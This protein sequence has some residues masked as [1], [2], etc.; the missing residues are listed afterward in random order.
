MPVGD[1]EVPEDLKRRYL[2]TGSKPELFRRVVDTI[3]FEE[4]QQ[5][6]SL[7]IEEKFIPAGNTLVAGVHPILPNCSIIGEVSDSNFEEVARRA[8]QLWQHAIGIGFDLTLCTD[9]VATLRRLSELSK[10]TCLAW[11]RPIRGNMATLNASHPKVSAFIACKTHS[12]TAANLLFNFNISVAVEDSFMSRA[13]ADRLSPEFE[14][15]RAIAQ[16]AW[17]YGDPGVVFLDRVQSGCPGESRIVT[18]V[19]CGEQFMHTNETCTLGAMNLDA[20][21]KENQFDYSDFRTSVKLAIRFLDAVIDTYALPDLAMKSKSQHL[22]RIGLGVMGFA[23]LLRTLDVPYHSPAALEMAKHLSFELTAAAR[24][25]SQILAQEKG[26][27]AVA[28]RRNIT[29]TCVAPTGGIRRLVAAE[30]YGI[31]PL[32]CEANQIPP[33]FAVEMLAAWQANVENAISKTVNLPTEATPNEIV[34]IFVCAYRSKC[35]GITVYRDGCRSNQPKR[36]C[37]GDQCNLS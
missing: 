37:D 1:Y 36:V 13:L 31:E 8:V 35:K 17:T 5:F 15:L 12:E 32:F 6:Y 22:R 18:A 34:E 25:A 30:G 19:P 26:S 29:V 21:V 2:F 33:L 23:T 24:N 9:P 3:G 16:A 4:K 28:G 7:L 27:C 11:D 14:V 10:S 20:F